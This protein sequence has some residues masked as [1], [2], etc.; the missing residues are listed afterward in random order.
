M[1]KL[2][3]YLKQLFPMKYDTIYKEDGTWYVTIWR[4]WLGRCFAIKKYALAGEPD[5]I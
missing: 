1:D 4:M 3:W 5:L 2:I